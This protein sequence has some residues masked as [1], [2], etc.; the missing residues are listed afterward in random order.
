MKLEITY[1]VMKLKITYGV[2]KLKITYGWR[3]Q[4][5]HECNFDEVILPMKF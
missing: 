5:L 1:G 2:M 4:S 3:D